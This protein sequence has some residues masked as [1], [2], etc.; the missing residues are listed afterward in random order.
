ME[1]LCKQEV[2]YC[3]ETS[4]GNPLVL[5]QCYLQNTGIIKASEKCENGGEL[6]VWHTGA[7]ISAVIANNS[8]INTSVDL[9]F[10][11]WE[12]TFCGHCKCRSLAYLVIWERIFILSQLLR[13]Q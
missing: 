8:N 12:L 9:F 13:K 1:L 5:H 11:V 10:E 2:D 4:K 3:V 7:P 6:N